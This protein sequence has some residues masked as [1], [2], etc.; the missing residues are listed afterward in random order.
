MAIP[1][2]RSAAI[3]IAVIGFSLLAVSARANLV[4]NG[5]FELY[6][7]TAPKGAFTSVAPTD[8]SGGG[9]DTF[10]AA[11]G[12]ATTAPYIVYGPFPAT[13]PAGGNFVEA[14]GNVAFG[15]AFYQTIGGL[16]PGGSYML[17][18]YQAA[19][20]QIGFDGA[21]TE[22]WEVTFGS[23]TKYSALMSTPAE[24]VTDWEYE[25]MTF[26]ATAASEVLTFLAY[27]DGGSDVNLPPTVFLDAV[28]LEVPE[29]VSLSLMGVGLVALG[30]VR[31][32][33]RFK[34]SVR[35]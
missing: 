7:G 32:R 17:S 15:G 21:T 10:I 29:P 3:G 5:N 11:P 26:V 30:A 20:Q 1:F 12:T 28:D 19:G 31:R 16:T 24:G 9:G 25:T 6:T 23:T 2:H 35:A 34:P 4:T 13:S 18:F 22:Q 33:W 8:W 14:D 27:G